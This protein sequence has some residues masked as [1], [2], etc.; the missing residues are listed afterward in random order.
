VG[1]ISLN[2]VYFE[3]I[4]AKAKESVDA[5]VVP[6][7]TELVDPAVT[8][9]STEELKVE[10]AVAK[11]S[12]PKYRLLQG[13]HSV[14][15]SVRIRKGDVIESDDDLVKLHGKEKFEYVVE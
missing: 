3:K 9:A 11:E 2:K 4:M 12:K 8:V 1:G 7:S 14:S 15:E 13:S 6:E 5:T 10:V